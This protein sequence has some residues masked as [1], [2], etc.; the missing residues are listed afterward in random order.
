MSLK[1]MFFFFLNGINEQLD[2][3][4]TNFFKKFLRQSDHEKGK[5][6][7]LKHNVFSD[8]IIREEA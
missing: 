3:T 6:A 8:A 1:S 5:D 4:W 7:G 2:Q